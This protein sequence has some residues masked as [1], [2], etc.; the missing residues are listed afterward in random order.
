MSTHDDDHAS[1]ERLAR[2]LH[3]RV[4]DFGA[5][6]PIGL[7]AVKRTARGVRRRR[8]LVTGLAALVVV[9][10]AVPTAVAVGGGVDRAD[11]PLPATTSPTPSPSPSAV[12][13]PSEAPSSPAPSPTT[14]DPS[15]SSP[16]PTSSDVRIVRLRADTE[17]HGGEPGIPYLLGYQI[18][19]PD[20]KTVDL[21]AKDN[22]Q[23]G[24]FGDGWALRSTDLD[25]HGT[26]ALVFLDAQ[27][28]PTGEKA[29]MGSVAFSDDGSLLAYATPGGKLMVAWDGP[30]SPAELRTEG[31]GTIDPVAVLGSQRCDNPE[32]KG[33]CVV[34]YDQTTADGTTVAKVS[35]RHGIVDTVGTFR[36]VDDVASDGRVAGMVSAS[37]TGSCSAVQDADGR[38]LWQTCDYALGRFS[39]DGRYIIGHPAYA[40]GLGDYL[41]AVLDARTGKPLVE[42]RT[43]RDS[44]VTTTTW[45]ADGTLLTML[46]DKGWALMRLDE[47]GSYSSV[48]TGRIAGSQERTPVV[49]AGN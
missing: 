27:G 49:F 3:D 19:A 48:S 38:R 29:M 47:S 5:D 40:D 31:P 30:G 14:S 25:D 22:V 10:V 39:P 13:M 6:A 41:V 1:T 4:D 18:V 36:K 42:Y 12:P 21:D 32:G 35:D 45:D 20:G 16:T 17:Q 26:A 15:P 11:H 24:R 44:F 23:L 28:R 43:K 33:G 37:D 34:Y 46:Y 2:G 7:E 8:R 9:A